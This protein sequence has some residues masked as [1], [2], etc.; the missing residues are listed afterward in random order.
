LKIRFTPNVAIRLRIIM[1]VNYKKASFWKRLVAYLIDTALLI[2]ASLVIQ[3]IFHLSDIVEQWIFVLI[4]FG[5]NI[6][7]DYYFQRTL[8]KR[9]LK[10]EVIQTNGTAPNLL[11]CFYRNFGKYISF[12]PLGC[13]Y[14][15]ILAPHQSQTIHDELGHC[16]V[17]EKKKTRRR[18][19]AQ[20]S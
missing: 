6:S 4:F 14:F 15:R 13:G 10:L 5:Y 17:V 8:G 11:S 1:Q 18:H 7:M 2:I 19:A 9:L 3:Y 16:F 20:L 12:L